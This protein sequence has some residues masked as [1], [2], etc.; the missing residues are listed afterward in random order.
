[1]HDTI[2]QG[3]RL[4]PHT[5][6]EGREIVRQELRQLREKWE[7]FTDQLSDTQRKLEVSLVQLSS[8]ED[9][10]QQFR[11]WMSE[12]EVKVQAEADLKAT[13]QEKKVQLQSHRVQHQDILSHQHVLDSL[14]DRARSLAQPSSAE[15]RVARLLE[16]VT[17]HY[18]DLC[19]VSQDLLHRFENNVADHQQ[20]QDA[21]QQYQ[22]QFTALAGRVTACSDVSGDRFAVQNKLERIKV[23][24]VMYGVAF[25][26]WQILM[27]LSPP[28][29]F[30]YFLC[31]CDCVRPIVHFSS[32][33]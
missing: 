10:F 30:I 24:H 29:S 31:V 19:I 23:R 9:S 6:S 28:E 25:R 1:M 14:S 15:S 20:Y 18:R 22:D 26:I 32:R 16:D 12:T 13:L 17:K 5:A 33:N 2:E 11:T 21:L 4:Y 27:W 3:E 7:G 8:Y